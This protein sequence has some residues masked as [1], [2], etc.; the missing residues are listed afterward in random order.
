MNRHPI[1]PEDMAYAGLVMGRHESNAPV[2]L[3][4]ATLFAE[5]FKMAIT[6]EWREGWNAC[7]ARFRSE[8]SAP[9]AAQ[10]MVTPHVSQAHFDRAF[11]DTPAA[12]QPVALPVIAW[13]TMGS[14]DGKRKFDI[15]EATS[16]PRYV[17]V[18]RDYAWQPLVRLSDA[19]AAL[20][21]PVAAQ[22]QEPVAWRITNGEGGYNYVE[23]EPELFAVNWAARYKRKHDPLYT[24]PTAAQPVTDAEVDAAM[25][26]YWANEHYGNEDNM[27]AAL[28]A[29]HAARGQK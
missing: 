21:A 23:D 11:P 1:H 12:A 4:D 16:N 20:A 13:L 7:T 25:K 3:M 22:P 29:H 10:P 18:H 2:E 8:S 24:H 27:R 5:T 19:Q 26:V 6:K 17:E 14:K 9:V 15:G 28:E